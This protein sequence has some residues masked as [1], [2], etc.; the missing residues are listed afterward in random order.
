MC[1]GSALVAPVAKLVSL[2]ARIGVGGFVIG[3]GRTGELA[4]GQRRTVEQRYMRLDA[5]LEQL[6]MTM[7]FGP[8]VLMNS[9]PPSGR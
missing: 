9:G 3:E 7:N 1:M 4:L 8:S 5:A 2:W 6:A